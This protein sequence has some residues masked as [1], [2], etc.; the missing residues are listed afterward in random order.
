MK[1]RKLS[2]VTAMLLSAFVLAGFVYA[3][4]SKIVTIEG[5]IETGTYNVGFGPT[6]II[7]DNEFEK[8]VG[9]VTAGLIDIDND[10]VYDEINVTIDNAYPCYEAYIDCFIHNYGSIPAKIQDI[11]VNAPSELTVEINWFIYEGMQ[12][13]P[14][15]EVMAEISVHVEQSADQG[16]TYTFTGTIDT[17]Q[18]N[19]YTP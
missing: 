9:N 12:I 5:T 3:H 18:W 17:I 16:S 4:W 11:T 15:D 2:I 14:E 6:L 19:E 10:G 8:D 7:S 1:I 13:D